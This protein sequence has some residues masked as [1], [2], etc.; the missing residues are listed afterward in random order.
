[1]KAI[2]RWFRTL[3]GILFIVLVLFPILVVWICAQIITLRELKIWKCPIA[4][5]SWYYNMFE[6]I[7]GSNGWLLS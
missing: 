7:I 4:I 1:M 2:I 5:D 3:G 6:K